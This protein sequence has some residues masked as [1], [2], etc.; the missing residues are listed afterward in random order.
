[1]SVYG[2]RRAGLLLL[3][4]GAG[5]LTGQATT[6]YLFVL[7]IAL[8]IMWWLVYDLKSDDYYRKERS[9]ADN[10]HDRVY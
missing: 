1:M 8:S 3:V 4:F 10:R 9:D 7:Y 6:P 2:L 5:W